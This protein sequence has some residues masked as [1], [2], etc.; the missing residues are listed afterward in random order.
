MTVRGLSVALFTLALAGCGLT[1]YERP[2]VEVPQAWRGEAQTD[3]SLVERPW[4]ELF[5]DPELTALIETALAGNRDLRIAAERIEL[6]RAR[7]GIERSYLFPSV[8]GDAAYTRQ[9]QPAA[10]LD[11][12]VTSSVTSVGLAVPTWE[13]DLWGRVRAATQVAYRDLLASTENRRAFEVSL[14]AEVSNA[15]LALLEL[16]AQ[17][18]TALNTV[19]TRSE[20][21]RVVRSRFEGGVVSGAD[22]AQAESNLA[23]AERTVVLLQGQRMRAEN[24][25]SVLLGRNPGPIARARK[26]GDYPAT[27]TLPAGIPAQLLE[28]RPD[29]L[30]A[31]QQLIGAQAN[32]DAARKAYFPAISLTGFL[33]FASPELDALLEGDRYAWSVTPAITAPIFT[34]GRLR[35]NV[36]AAQAQQRIALEQYLG[37]VQNAFREVDDALS[38]YEQSRKEREALERV[39]KA[40][41]ERLR[42][43]DLRY[44]GGVTIYLEVLLAEQDLFDSE[45]QLVQVTRN[46]Y[47]SVVQLYAALGGG[48]QPAAPAAAAPVPSAPAPAASVQPEGAA[49][50]AQQDTVEVGRDGA[51]TVVNVHYGR[52]IGGTLMRAPASGWPATMRVRLHGFRE[53]E[54]FTAHA[55]NTALV[56]GLVRPEGQPAGHRCRLDG[57]E[58]DALR[59]TSNLYE[60]T[61]PRALLGRADVPVEVRWVDYWR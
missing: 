11:E 46:V 35:S 7:Y 56:C 13:I 31:E 21:L 14:I 36:E 58:I 2:G 53:L 61:L 3:R 17:I 27:P 45:L 41:R 39:V 18:E 12:N 19:K 32:I 55:G 20:S 23:T 51:D 10:G 49:A 26:L 52:G 22:L 57:R 9:R 15:Y 1:P 37:S 42:L 6:A 25:L 28:R 59:K 54:S 34:A 48:W 47:S 24:G 33:G 4:G 8:V 38:L 50:A 30:A 40:N 5:A 43:A 16:D 44:R 60:V 29:I